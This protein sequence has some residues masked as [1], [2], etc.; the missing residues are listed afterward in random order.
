LIVSL[1]YVQKS[2]NRIKLLLISC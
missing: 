2:E 1:I